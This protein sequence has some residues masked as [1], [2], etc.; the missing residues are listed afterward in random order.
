MAENKNSLAHT[1]QV[2]VTE[3]TAAIIPAEAKKN[4]TDKVLDKVNEYAKAGTLMLPHNY[5]AGNAL[6]AAWLNISF[7]VD[8]D[9]RPAFDVC[10]KPSIA[11]ALLDMCVQGLNPA[12][13]QCYFIVHGKE[14]T[15]MR[16]YFGTCAALRRI[17]GIDGVYAQVIYADDVFEYV[18]ENGNRV[19][20]KHEQKIENID[21]EKI[22]G[23][24][25]VIVKDGKPH[26]EIM[27]MK[28]IETAW[29]HRSN[30]GSVQQE[31]PDQ[32]AMRTV[33]NRAAKMFVNTT[34]DSDLMI[35]SINR[36]T[37]DEYGD[38]RSMGTGDFIEADFEPCIVDE[39]NAIEAPVEEAT[40][41]EKPAKEASKPKKERKAEETAEQP[42][43]QPTAD[44]EDDFFGN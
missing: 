18:I 36:T 42:Q 19:I 31:Y 38:A 16:S 40:I 22:V 23:A 43:P 32:M 28:Q 3:P 24:Y 15:M 12:K 2:Q 5:H 8:K 11:N 27:T 10:T 39:P 33:I 17:K 7:V 29:S 34:D 9:K 20:T 37:A 41:A 26:C 13:K 35:E 25:C 6:K 4:I 14:L 1:E 21:L 44:V 30:S